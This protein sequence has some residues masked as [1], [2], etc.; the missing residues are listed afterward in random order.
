M[1]LFFKF[2]DP[3]RNLIMYMGHSV[4][5]IAKKFGTCA[6]SFQCSSSYI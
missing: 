5:P 3:L 4:E 6:K 2:Y 1:L